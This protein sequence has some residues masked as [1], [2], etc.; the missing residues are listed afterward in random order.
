MSGAL[1][2]LTSFAWALR[3]AGIPVTQDQIAGMARSL[4]LIDP[5]EGRQVHAALRSLAVSDPTHL[6][7]FDVEF[8]RFFRLTDAERK[9]VI[10]ADTA[11]HHIHISAQTFA[12]LSDFIHERDLS[13][14]KCVSCILS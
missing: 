8:A 13:S 12:Q 5:A 10:T 4:T 3:S 2:D 7:I 9:L 1:G 6:P 11:A 14:K